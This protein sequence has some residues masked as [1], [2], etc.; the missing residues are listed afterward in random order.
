MRN[1]PT[2]DCNTT[3]KPRLI[4]AL[5]AAAK[6]P[7]PS[8]ANRSRRQ[9]RTRNE[10]KD[11]TLSCCRLFVACVVLLAYAPLCLATML[12]GQ[13]DADSF[14]TQAR[15]INRNSAWVRNRADILSGFKNM[16][17][18]TALSVEDAE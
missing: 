13:P 14:Q 9:R 3:T 5:S 16:Y 8:S 18:A 1:A 12:P 17:H 6:G 11:F 15:Q 4:P 2:T 10:T 7:E